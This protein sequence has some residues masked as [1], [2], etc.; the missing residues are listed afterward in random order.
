MGDGG[1][2]LENHFLFMDNTM[3][4]IKNNKR[5]EN[6]INEC[7]RIEEDSTYTAETHYLIANSLSKKS[8]WFKFIP[9]IITGI[10]ALA[11]LLGSPDWVSWITLVSSI[12]A[13]TNT[14]LEPESKAREHEFAAKS[15]TVL[16]HEVRSLYESFKDFIDE[17][18]F[19]HE[20]KRLREKYNW[21]VQTTPP[22]DEKNFEKARGRIKKGIHKPDFQKNENG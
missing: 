6:L 7:K 19:Y 1:N 3:E 22:T 8:F 20:V 12:I 10:S 15:F 17:K 21:L 11:L 9:V 2:Y 13:I 5:M 14:I 16:K 4:N 18:D